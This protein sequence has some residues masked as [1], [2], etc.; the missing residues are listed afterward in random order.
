MNISPTVWVLNGPN[1]NLLGE[2]EPDTY[3]HDT[4]DSIERKC[5]SIADSLGLKIEFKQSNHE[6]ELVAW[7]QESRKLV[8]GLAI[9]AGA[10]THTS[11]AL[12]DALKLLSI[13][14]VEVHLSNIYTREQ[15]RHH[16]FIS[17]LAK[18]IICGFGA[19]SYVLAIQ[20]LHSIMK[21]K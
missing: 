4:L 5:V 13:P 17:P 6:G 20:A 14:I 18:G 1:L 7:I 3:G 8:D 19:N 15:F 12:H 11:V 21:L 2:R 10:Y 9:N 16:S